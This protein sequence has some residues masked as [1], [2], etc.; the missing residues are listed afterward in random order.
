ML[1]GGKQFFT[2]IETVFRCN[3]VDNVCRK[4]ARFD[5]GKVEEIVEVMKKT[6]TEQ[7]D[8]SKMFGT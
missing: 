3:V 8:V 1:E 4:L 2:A 7:N 5:I 6:L